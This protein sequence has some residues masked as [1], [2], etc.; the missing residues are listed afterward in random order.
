M[1]F[2]IPVTT[3]TL[4]MIVVLV[5]SGYDL[6]YR[7]IPNWLVLAGAVAGFLNGGVAYG[8]HGLEGSLLGFL[9]GFCLY[10]PLYVVRARGAGD[11]KLLAAMGAIVGV[12]TCFQ[13]AVYSAIIGGLFAIALALWKKRFSKTMFNL[14]VIVNELMQRRMPYRLDQKLDVRHPDSLRI[15]HAV[16]LATGTLTF[17]ALGLEGLGL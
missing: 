4:L 1:A 8:W 12:G 11:V 7:R 2:P 14:S 16:V 3:F 6:R 17:V 9:T 13:I 15:P 10:L 5:A